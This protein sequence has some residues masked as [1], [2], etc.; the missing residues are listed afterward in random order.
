MRSHHTRIRRGSVILGGLFLIAVW[1]HFESAAKSSPIHKG[2]TAAEW[3][4][5]ENGDP[6]DIITLSP[7]TVAFKAMGTNSIPFLLNVVKTPQSRMARLYGKIHPRLPN[8]IKARV[9]PPASAYSIQSAAFMI[10]GGFP[11]TYLDPYVVEL[12]SMIP[13]LEDGSIRQLGCLVIKKAAT[14]C[15][16]SG[17]KT[18]YF[19]TLIND[20]SFK[21]SLSAAI[22]LSRVDN[23]ITNGVQTLAAAITNEHL[24]GSV[25]FGG[26]EYI[27]DIQERAYNALVEVDPR[28][29]EQFESPSMFTDGGHAGSFFFGPPSP[30]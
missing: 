30:N 24:V 9:R 28:M 26:P 12:M 22:A 11:D 1:I 16:D 10:L 6:S 13:K 2:K 20:P 3:F 14:R 8:P 29:A 18:E 21:I 5:G 17:K 7:A 27:T 23:T 15:S 25:F 19:T 4:Y